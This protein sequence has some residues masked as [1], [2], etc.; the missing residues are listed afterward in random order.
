VQRAE[1]RPVDAVAGHQLGGLG[2]QGLGLGGRAAL[3]LGLGEQLAH[4]VK[5][6]SVHDGDPSVSAV[7]IIAVH[8][9]LTA[10]RSYGTGTGL[11]AG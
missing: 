11:R 10:G 5:K 7:A 9:P 2:G 8:P 4:P 3:V 1:E 6:I